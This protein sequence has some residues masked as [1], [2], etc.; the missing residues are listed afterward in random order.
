MKIIELLNKIANGEEL[1]KRIMYDRFN[2]IFDD[3]CDNYVRIDDEDTSLNWNFIALNRLDSEVE[4]LDNNTF[5][6]LTKDS[7]KNII[8]NMFED[9]TPEQFEELKKQVLE[10]QDIHLIKYIEKLDYK[11][12]ELNSP[13]FNESWLM[14]CIRANRG[15][16]NEIIDKINEVE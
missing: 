10:K 12:E 1:P 15:K 7:A 3:N 5:E 11:I 8:Q 6:N 2:Y 4:I 16:I 13:S 9:L 14:N